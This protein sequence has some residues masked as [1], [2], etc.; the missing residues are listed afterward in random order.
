M[1]KNTLLLFL[2][3]SCLSLAQNSINYKGEFINAL[4]EKDNQTGIW[5]LYDDKN[6]VLITTEFSEGQLIA[7]TNYYKD[8][9]L[10]ASYNNSTYK[11]EIYKDSKTIVA[12]FLRKEDHS[13]TLVD[14]ND[15][16]LDSETLRYFYLQ[17]GEVL[18]M[19]YGGTQELFTYIGNNFISNGN[20]GKVKVQFT[21]DVKGY[22]T[23]IQVVESTNTK[24]NEEAV[25]VV[26]ILPRWQPG[27]QAGG[28]VKCLF[29]I[30]ININ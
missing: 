29:T 5:K 3:C 4:D 6:N 18:P 12:Y 24:L 16:E 10:I 21:I 26:G 11:L 1:L 20:K 7:S 13:Q 23:D 28:F 19:F 25:R 8:S 30:P 27:F 9:K 2:F 17:V 22:T 15:K 14:E